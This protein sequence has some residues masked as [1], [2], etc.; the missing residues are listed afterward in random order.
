V[1]SQY[2]QPQFYDWARSSWTGGVSYSWGWGP[3]QP[4]FFADL[5][6]DLRP[7]YASRQ[8]TA[9]PTPAG[10]VTPEVKLPVAEEAKRHIGDERTGS[11]QPP[12]AQPG[13][14]AEPP[15]LK[16]RIFVVAS[17]L[18]MV[19]VENKST[20]RLSSCDVSEQMAPPKFTP[21]GKLGGYVLSGKAGACAQDFVTELDVAILQ[22]TLNEFRA[23]VDSMESL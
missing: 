14:E 20:C 16:T 18:D 2:F 12:T 1:P 23:P 6:A 22:D 17:P 3:S 5:A 10:P 9:A 8:R 19:S 4:W 13:A 21:K 11:T 7:V 15:V